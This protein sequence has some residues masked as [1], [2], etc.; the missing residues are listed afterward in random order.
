LVHVR[1]FLQEVVFLSLGQ[2][3][4]TTT[5]PTLPSLLQVKHLPND[6]QGFLPGRLDESA[7]VHDHDVG[8]FRLSGQR[9]AVL[10]QLA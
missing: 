2:A 5:E 1:N 8:A 7:R 10:G 9:V 4:A 6:G 3:A